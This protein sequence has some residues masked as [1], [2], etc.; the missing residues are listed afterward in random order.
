M[1]YSTNTLNAI[2]RRSPFV[3]DRVN[4]AKRSSMMAAVHSKNTEPELLV[5]RRVYALG[6]RYRLHSR[7]LPGKPDLV[8]KGKRKVIFVHGCF[9]HRH[10]GCSKASTPKTR[11][12]FWKQ[13]LDANV[14]HDKSVIQALKKDGWSTLTVWQCELKKVET[15]TK[16]LS[17]FLED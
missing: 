14:V 16:R 13:K 6:F 1:Q 12:D 10:S 7:E 11:A 3:T 5:R 17:R 15:L 8:F 2:K 4:K 9:W